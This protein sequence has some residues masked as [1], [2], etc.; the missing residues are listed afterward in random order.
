MKEPAPIREYEQ[1]VYVYWYGPNLPTAKIGHSN[2]PDKRI[3]QLG[4]DTGVPDHLASFAAIVWLDRRREQVEARAHAMAASFRKSGEWFDLTASAALGYIISAAEELNVRYEVEDRAGLLAVTRENLRIAAE[5][6]A[7]EAARARSR[8]EKWGPNWR[9]K[10]AA[11]EATEEAAAKADETALAA[12]EESAWAA[13]DA[14]EADEPNRAAATAAAQSAK[15]K[16]AAA[17]EAKRAA[18]KAADA[19]A[20]DTTAGYRARIARFKGRK[21]TPVLTNAQQTAIDAEGNARGVAFWNAKWER[22]AAA[23]KKGSE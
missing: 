4:N 23:R 3:A 9:E 15:R 1:A 20:N 6:S 10:E 13:T 11:E 8:I 12:E 17:Q 2:S 21:A 16:A 18:R 19:A 14:D 22:D 7:K 5:E